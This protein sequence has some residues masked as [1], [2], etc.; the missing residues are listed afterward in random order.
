VLRPDGEF[1]LE[2]ESAVPLA[3]L[4]DEL[5]GVDVATEGTELVVGRAEVEEAEVVAGGLEEEPELDDLV[6]ELEGLELEELELDE[7][8][9][10]GLGL[11]GL[12]LEGLGLGELGLDGL[13][14]GE[15]GLE[16]GAARM[17]NPLE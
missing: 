10:E 2:V 7:L 12:G 11:D 14:L 16:I 5:A 3:E 4:A 13:G 15:L 6:L 17:R 8:E 1:A 9:L